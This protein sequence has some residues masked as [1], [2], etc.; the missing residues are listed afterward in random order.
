MIAL[1]K[2]LGRGIPLGFSKLAPLLGGIMGLLRNNKLLFGGIERLARGRLGRGGLLGACGGCRDG[3][4]GHGN[5][6]LKLHGARALGIAAC[7]RCGKFPSDI[8]EPILQ[9][10]ESVGQ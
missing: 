7:G 6:L 3:K 4:A 5:L 10:M 1:G 9:Q 8:R 2:L